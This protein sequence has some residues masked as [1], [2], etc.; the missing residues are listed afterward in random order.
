MK[1]EIEGTRARLFGPFSWEASKVISQLTGRKLWKSMDLVQIEPNAVNLRML[2]QVPG[3]Q[4]QDD[5]GQLKELRALSKAL[6]QDAV[7]PIITSEFRPQRPLGDFQQQI[8]GLSWSRKVYGILL[9]MGLRKTATTFVNIGYLVAKQK[10]TG[11]LIV[12]P[13][14]LQ[15]QWLNEAMPLD[16]DPGYAVDKFIWKGKPPKWKFKRQGVTEFFAINY[17]SV[18][19]AKGFPVVRDFMKRHQG[20]SMMVL[21]ESQRIKTYD[22]KRTEAV[23]ALGELATYRRILTGTLFTVNISDAWSQFKF[24]DERILGYKYITPFRHHFCQFGYMPGQI[25]GSKNEEE[26]WGL[27]APH[28]YR[29]TKEELLGLEPKTYSVRPYVMDPVTA[30]HYNELKHLFLTQLDDGTIV[31]VNSA[32]VMMLRLQQ[33]ICGYLPSDDPEGHMVPISESR[34]QIALEAIEQFTGP[35]I[36]WA[37]FRHDIERLERALSK[38]HGEGSTVTYYGADSLSQRE[39]A[40]QDF[41]KRRARF[42]VSNPAVGGIGLD[43]L[44]H[45]CS[46]AIYY[47]NS[48]NAEHRW[49]SEDRIWRDGMKGTASYLDIVARGSVDLA[50][51]QNLQKKKSMSDLTLDEIRRALQQEDPS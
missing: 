13:N 4:F 11:V 34:I 17:E 32:M 10:L 42:F 23:W 46:T 45:V 24:L 37:R 22:T 6:T 47:S 21:D 43:G 35:L 40:K 33:V 36:I 49:H 12:C 20:R 50:I 7:V 31:N 29:A 39:A 16:W 5:G 18:H 41:L 27:V 9:E 1:C 14:G 44:Q 25:V 38:A 8:L 28:V 15:G 51:R 30:K 48:F 19:S 2:Q 3:I 26:F